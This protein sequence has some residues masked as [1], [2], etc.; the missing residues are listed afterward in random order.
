L[1]IDE[2]MGTDLWCR[3]IEKE[4]KNVRPAF[5]HW[6][7][8]TVKDARDG[9]KLVGYQEITCHMVFDIKMDFM[10]KAHYVAGG[11]MMEPPAAAT[12][13]SVVS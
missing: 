10:R 6:D 12:Y 4:M 8:G 9:K 1:R 2:E 3:A 11:H 7:Q 13:S 5:E